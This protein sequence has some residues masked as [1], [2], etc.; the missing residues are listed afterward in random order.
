PF[1]NVTLTVGGPAI[2]GYQWKLDNG[3]YSALV[4]VTNPLTPNAVIPPINLTNLSN[5]AHQV[6]VIIKN[7]AG[8]FQSSNQAT[9]SKVFTVN[10]A[11][12]GRVRINEVLADN[13]SALN[14]AGTNPDAI[15][16][17]NDGK[18]TIDLS[19]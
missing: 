5:G 16:L 14:N 9:L 6:S 1:N 3:A 7:D 4:N 18:G 2:Y 13:V 19:D 15:E 12:A 8:V 17:Y 11:I 10:T